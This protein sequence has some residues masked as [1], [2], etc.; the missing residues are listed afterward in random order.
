MR[1]EPLAT[2]GQLPDR[3]RAGSHG[4]RHQAL[5]PFSPYVAESRLVQSKVV[6]EGKLLNIRMT[7]ETKHFL[8]SSQSRLRSIH[9]RIS[10][11]CR[12]EN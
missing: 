8:A 10:G 4:R 5:L 2:S 12:T 6:R 9:Q 1:A 3:L 11:G 7:L